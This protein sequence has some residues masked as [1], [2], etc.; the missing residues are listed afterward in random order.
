MRVYFFL[1]LAV[2]VS[3]VDSRVVVEIEDILEAECQNL[4]Y[5]QFRGITEMTNNLEIRLGSS[6]SKEFEA[7][8]S[9]EVDREEEAILFRS[10]EFHFDMDESHIQGANECNMYLY[11]STGFS[12]EHILIFKPEVSFW[13]CIERENCDPDDEVFVFEIFVRRE[14]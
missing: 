8:I 9:I 12:T 11:H 6:N 14:D 2:L 7:D 1:F 4:P 10:V 13:E 5:E 3:C